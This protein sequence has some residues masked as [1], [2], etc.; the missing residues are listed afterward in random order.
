M[1]DDLM[2]E[3]SLTDYRKVLRWINEVEWGYNGI[4]DY[5]NA[6]KNHEDVEARVNDDEG[7]K[8]LVN[9]LKGLDT[10]STRKKQ[11][12]LRLYVDENDDKPRLTRV[13]SR[14]MMDSI[15]NLI[16]ELEGNA[17][18]PNTGFT[19]SDQDVMLSLLGVNKWSLKWEDRTIA[20]DV[21]GYFP[22]LNKSC[23]NLER[24]GI[25][26]ELKE[27]NY[28]GN[29]RFRDILDKAVRKTKAES[30]DAE[31]NQSDDKE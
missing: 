15:T 12:V 26:K 5:M 25:Y 10:Y 23:L 11:L 4:Y 24:Y 6:V 22:Y 27:E 29:F 16:E 18:T 1:R 20:E 14:D 8:D 2:Y 31:E 28:S 9:V 13:L 17:E 7:A 30:V 19:F 21:N 3:G